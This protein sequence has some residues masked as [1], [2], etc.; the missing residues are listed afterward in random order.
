[1]PA[2]IEATGLTKRFP[3]GGGLLLRARR[4]VHAV[5]DVSLAIERG[6]TLGLVGESGCG[7]STVGRLLLGLQRPTAG[8]VVFDG[9]DL[10]ALDE[11]ALRK[12]RRRMQMV[13]QDPYGAL[14]PRMPI[15]DAVA[16]PLVIHHPQL[17]AGERRDR[18]LQLLGRVGLR[19]DQA[20]RLPAEFSGGQRQRIVIARAL[21][22]EP[23]LL[24][25]DEPVSALDVSIQAQIVNLLADLQ[26]E[27][28][29]SYLFVSHDL[30]VVRHVA[31]RVAV[32]YLG[33]VV[34][35]APTEPLFARPRHPYTASLLAAIPDPKRRAAG[36]PRRLLLVGDPPSPIAPPSGCAL[37][38]RC[39]L[40]PTLGAADQERCAREAP[41]LAGDGHRVAC[42]HAD[43][44]DD[45]R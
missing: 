22:A 12:L 17:S 3:V 45:I 34:E 19:A 18:V 4:A 31:H 10:G 15:A 13:F 29:L 43:R 6:T 9:Q 16:E 36:T 38:P 8:R 35:E 32:M 20:Q 14:N 39:P 28:Q 2:L 37:H 33:R 30:K 27:R 24:F 7:K 25:A 42:H 41:A 26:R 11:E 21:A 5:S 40:R 23:E 1:M 44:L